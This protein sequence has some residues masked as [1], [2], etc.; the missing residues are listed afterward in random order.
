MQRLQGICDFILARG[1][2]AY[3]LTPL[4]LLVL[5]AKEQD[6]DLGLGQC[7]AQL[8]AARLLHQRDGGTDGPVYGCV[9]NADTWHFLKLD[10]SKLTLDENRRFIVEVDI[11]L[12]MILASVHPS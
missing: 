12:G 8:V 7:A 9:T 5:E 3:V 6:M 4:I 1:E 11:V 2:T 10:G